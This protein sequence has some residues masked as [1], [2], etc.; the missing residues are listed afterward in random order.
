MPFMLIFYIHTYL[1]G[2][3]K[4]AP[5]P[6][7][8][9]EKQVYGIKRI[10]THKKNRGRI[11]YQVIWRGYDATEESRLKEEDL[12]NASNLLQAYQLRHG[13]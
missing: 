4:G 8:A 10:I 3:S 7:V 1:V 6:I 11:V 12:L 2:P 9:C 13:I 5:N